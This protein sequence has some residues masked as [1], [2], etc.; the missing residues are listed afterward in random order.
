MKHILIVLSCC[1]LPIVTVIDA[2]AETPPHRK[3]GLWEVKTTVSN[4]PRQFTGQI[5]VDQ[6]SDDL[7][8]Q[9]GKQND[10]MTCSKTS[11]YK[12]GST[13]V[14]ES[15]CQVESSTATTRAVFTGSFESSYR[16]ESKSTYTPPLMGIKEGTTVMDAK[17]LGPCKPGQTPGDIIVPEIERMKK[18]MQG[19]AGNP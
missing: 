5:C 6:N 9:E 4:S 11:I 13:W 7:W 15:V 2:T 8:T 18:M 19:G 17:W 16:V 10:Q 14:S 1:L 12:E 3:S